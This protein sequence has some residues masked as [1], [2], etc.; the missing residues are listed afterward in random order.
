MPTPISIVREF[1]E[2]SSRG[3]LQRHDGNGMIKRGWGIHEDEPEE[4]WEPDAHD[5]ELITEEL[6]L[7][8]MERITRSHVGPILEYSCDN[9]EY[10]PCDRDD[11]E[12]ADY[13]PMRKLNQ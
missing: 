9:C 12:Q 2:R 5:K 7:A 10:F 1:I 3:G 4:E 13:C 6:W 11:P 8:L